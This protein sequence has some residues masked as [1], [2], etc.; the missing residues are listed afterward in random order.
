MKSNLLKNIWDIR[1]QIGA[2]CDY[3]LKRLGALIRREEDKV[4]KRL[5]HPPKPTLRQKRA[6]VAA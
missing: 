3:D 6:T 4:G 2:E 1:D 5:V